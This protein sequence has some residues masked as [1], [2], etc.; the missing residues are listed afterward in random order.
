[1]RKK[2]EKDVFERYVC[3]WRRIGVLG[4]ERGSVSGRVV[5]RREW[6]GGR[7]EDVEGGGMG[8]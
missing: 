1:M 4:K 2:V 6:Q 5:K 8:A 3:D 7:V